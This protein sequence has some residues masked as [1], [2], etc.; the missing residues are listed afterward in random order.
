MGTPVPGESESHRNEDGHR[1]VMHGGR[2]CDYGSD[3]VQR[4]GEDKRRIWIE[5][6]RTQAMHHGFAQIAKEA[7]RVAEALR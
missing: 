7:I 3:I 2:R 5:V 6:P 1:F 4:G